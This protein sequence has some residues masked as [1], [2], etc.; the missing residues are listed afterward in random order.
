MESFFDLINKGLSELE[1]SLVP[2]TFSDASAEG[3]PPVTADLINSKRCRCNGKGRGI[4]DTGC[5]CQQFALLKG[6][7]GRLKRLCQRK[8]NKNLKKCKWFSKVQMDCNPRKFGPS[9]PI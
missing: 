1:P 2:G 9:V 4:M 8:R 7:C 6:K 5:P 3:Q